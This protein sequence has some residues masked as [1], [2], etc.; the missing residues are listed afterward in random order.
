MKHYMGGHPLALS[1]IHAAQPCAGW[2]TGWQNR[3]LEDELQSKRVFFG[4]SWSFV[5]GLV[6]GLVVGLVIL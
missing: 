6:V 2:Y 5:T 3:S 4:I 1:L